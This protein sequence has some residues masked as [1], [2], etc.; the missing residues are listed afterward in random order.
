MYRY[1]MLIGCSSEG[2]KRSLA[3]PVSECSTQKSI[4]TWLVHHRGFSLWRKANVQTISRGALNHWLWVLAGGLDTPLMISKG[5]GDVALFRAYSSY[6]NLYGILLRYCDVGLFWPLEN[7][8]P[9]GFFSS[10]VAFKENPPPK[11]YTYQ[12]VKFLSYSGAK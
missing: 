12:C 7:V 6:H 1:I 3:P 11:A 8:G 4:E 5:F 2:T 9:I 10:T